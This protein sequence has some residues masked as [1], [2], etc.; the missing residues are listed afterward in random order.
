MDHAQSPHFEPRW[1][2]ALAII[3]TVILLALLP[4]QI[5]LFPTWA[6][7]LAGIVVLSPMVAVSLTG[8]TPLRLRVERIVMALFVVSIMLANTAHL[9]KLIAAMLHGLAGVS[10][11][12]LLQS[13]VAVWAKNVLVFA[14][15]YWHIDRGGPGGRLSDGGTRP[16][17]LFPQAGAPEK[18]V[19]HGWRPTFVDYLFLA[20]STATAFSTTDVIPLTSRAKMLMMFESTI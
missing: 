13:S 11:L 2:V 16:D 19:P 4:D 18:D 15:A 14:L 8:A 20:Y 10:G 9:W 7:Y 5:S 12:A 1:P 17:W 3:T 6:P